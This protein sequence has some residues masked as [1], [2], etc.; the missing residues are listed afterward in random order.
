LQSQIL[1]FATFIDSQN[2][3]GKVITLFNGDYPQLYNNFEYKDKLDIILIPQT[4]QITT[5]TA[6]ANVLDDEILEL[7]EVYN[8]T[9]L[10]LNAEIELG[11]REKN[12]NFEIN[13]V[14]ERAESE[15][16]LEIKRIQEKAEKEITDVTDSYSKKVNESKELITNLKKRI[17]L[18]I[19]E[20]DLK[21][22]KKSLIIK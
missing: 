13:R 22:E 7:Q 2:L 20:R 15:M 16:N 12:A 10:L 3:I 5:N 11:N 8:L 6:V 21:N 1:E 14:K 17:N 18:I 9:K 19:K 4:I